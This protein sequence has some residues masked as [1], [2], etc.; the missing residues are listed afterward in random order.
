[1]MDVLD[2]ARRVRHVMLAGL[3]EF[4]GQLTYA[5]GIGGHSLDELILFP[6]ANEELGHLV[7]MI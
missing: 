4:R 5:N 2:P 6:P 3:V 1:M 7:V